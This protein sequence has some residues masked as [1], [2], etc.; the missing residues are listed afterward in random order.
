MR[1][2]RGFSCLPLATA[3]LAFFAAVGRKTRVVA[4]GAGKAL[5]RG[6]RTAA[7]VLRTVRPV[8]KASGAVGFRDRHPE[9]RAPEARVADTPDDAM[10]AGAVQ[11]PG[12]LCITHSPVESGPIAR[13]EDSKV[14]FL[15]FIR[16]YLWTIFC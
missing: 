5:V 6:A 12:D 3:P 10:A 15:H 8:R 13:V 11:Q 1:G 16:S 14:C 7:S 2:H 4:F 9:P